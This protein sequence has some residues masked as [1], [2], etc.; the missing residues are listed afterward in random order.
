M[1]PATASRPASDSL[2]PQP[3]LANGCPECGKR[4]GRFSANLIHNE[5]AILD[6]GMIEHVC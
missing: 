2:Y 4:N 5:Q 1:V 6:I 3:Y